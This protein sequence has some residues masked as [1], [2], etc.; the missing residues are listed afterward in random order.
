MLDLKLLRSDPDAAHAALE[1]RGAGE[2]LARV[3]ELD[4]R[5]RAILPQIEGLRAEQN[6]ANQAIGQAK[7][8]GGDAEQAIARMR[9]VAGRVKTL[10]D[11]LAGRRGRAADDAEPAPELRR[12]GRPGRGHRAARGG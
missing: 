12:A 11:E 3:L 1:R 6:E 4:E 9:E 10:A 7:A 8:S 2:R 5:R